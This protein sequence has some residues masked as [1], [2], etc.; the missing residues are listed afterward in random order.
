[1]VIYSESHVKQRVP[2]LN[3]NPNIMEKSRALKT[4]RIVPT[5]KHKELIQHCKFLATQIN[6]IYE[7]RSE[8]NLICKDVVL[9]SV[10]IAENFIGT[11]Y[12]LDRVFKPKLG[13]VPVASLHNGYLIE[14]PVKLLLELTSSLTE[15]PNQRLMKSVSSISSIQVFGKEDILRDRKISKLW[16]NSG[17]SESGRTFTV[18]LAPYR[19]EKAK[20]KLYS[21]VLELFG[22]QLDAFPLFRS[23][24]YH[25]S[26]KNLNPKSELE[27]DIAE[28]YDSLGV[29]RGRIEI[30]SKKKL[31]SI[32]SSGTIM[33]IEPEQAMLV[34]STQTAT[35]TS[36]SIPN[37]PNNPVVAIFDDG[38]ND[39]DYLPLQSWAGPEIV[40]AAHVHIEHGNTIFR[41]V[42]NAKT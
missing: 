18:W 25:Q 28:F 32:I 38:C 36:E 35:I 26:K 40:P 15:Y 27:K 8:L 21:K 33:R 11:G 16:E 30:N 14:A 3:L 13:F 34:G 7:K 42:S 23:S 20:D 41:I 10:G 22:D 9:L 5:M 17:V 12:I 24:N 6:E 37:L 39:S 1:M 29:R 2:R 31:R 4:G 19:N